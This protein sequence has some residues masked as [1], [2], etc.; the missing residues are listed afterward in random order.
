MDPKEMKSALKS[1]REAIRQKEYKEALKHCKSILKHDK[2]HYNALVFVGVAAEG[3]E[4]TEQALM[5]F[6]KAT[7]SDPS[8]LLAWQGLCRFY[9]KA[10]QDGHSS[11]LCDVYVKLMGLSTDSD[12]KQFEISMKLSRLLSSLGRQSDA[13]QTLKDSLKICGEENRTEVHQR[14]MACI[15]SQ[16]DLL[17]SH[18]SLSICILTTKDIQTMKSD[19]QM[20]ID[21]SE[22]DEICQKLIAERPQLIR[23]WEIT[24]RIC[25]DRSISGSCHGDLDAVAEKLTEISG[26]GTGILNALNGYQKLKKR[27][28]MDAKLC[29]MQGLKALGTNHLSSWIYLSKCHLAMHRK[30]DALLSANKAQK[31]LSQMDIRF[32]GHRERASCEVSLLQAAI[33]LEAGCTADDAE[34]ALAKGQEVLGQCADYAEAS[35]SVI[36]RSLLFLRQLDLARESIRQLKEMNCTQA[37]LLEGHLLLVQG[38]PQAAIEK[39]E[40]FVCLEPSKA[41]GHLLLAKALAEGQQWSAHF[42]HLLA[43]AKLDQYSYEVFLLLGHYYKKLIKDPQKARRCYQKAHDLNP[44]D[45]ESGCSLVDALNE[46][47]E[48]EAAVSVLTA[49]VSGA[50]SGGAKWAWLRLGLYQLKTDHA[51]SAVTSL[52]AALRADPTDRSCLECL[53]EAY[54]ARGSFP[55]ALRTFEKAADL[56]ASSIYSIY[57]I[58][59]LKQHL[60]QYEAAIV[61]YGS[62]LDLDSTHVPAL[63][64]CGETH[65]LL[66]ADALGESM[67]GR[68]VNH[69]QLAIALLTRAATKRPD[70]SCVWKLLGD[71]CGMLHALP[72]E[73]VK[74]QVPNALLS[75]E[76]QGHSVLGQR[77]LLALA[78][79]CYGMALKQ[80][81]Q[82]S[83][84]WHDLGVAYWRHS[85][86]SL[87]QR[88]SLAEKGLHAMRKAV[89][90]QPSN[91]AHWNTLGVIAADVEYYALAQHAFIKSIQVD[92]NNAAAWSHLGA[93]YLLSNR[94]ETAHEAFKT[95]QSLE[96]SFAT[97]WIGQ[98][99]VA[100]AVGHADAMDL[101]RHTTDLS[102]HRESALGYAHWVCHTLMHPVTSDLYDYAIIQ[103]RAVLTASDSMAKFTDCVT[104]DAVSFNF[105]GLLL[106]RQG[107]F[108]SA[109]RAF[110]RSCEIFRQQGSKDELRK[111]R[112]NHARALSALGE[113]NAALEIYEQMNVD[114]FALVASRALCLFE[115]ERLHDSYAMYEAALGIA[116][117]DASKSHTLTAMGMAAFRS[118]DHERAKTALFQAFQHSPPSEQGLLAL[119]GLG[120]ILK[121]ATLA[122]AVLQEIAHPLS[123]DLS[124]LSLRSALE[125]M[126]CSPASAVISHLSRAVHLQPNRGAAWLKLSKSLMQQ[127]R[128]GLAWHCAKSAEILDSSQE[129]VLVS[130]M[131]GL[132][133]G[134]HRLKNVHRRAQKAVHLYPDSLAAWCSLLACAQAERV[135]SPTEEEAE[136]SVHVTLAAQLMAKVE[137]QMRGHAPLH[138]WCVA[139][140]VVALMTVGRK[141][142]A[143][144]FLQQATWLYEDDQ[145]LQCL[146]ALVSQN[147]NV[148]KEAAT[149][150]SDENSLAWQFLI[151][152]YLDLQMPTEAEVVYGAW[153][154]NC[155]GYLQQIARAQF[156]FMAYKQLLKKDE[157]KWREVLKSN[158][159]EVM[160]QGQHA[161]VSAKLVVQFLQG[162]LALRDTELKKATK[163]FAYV[164]K[165]ADGESWVC[166]EADRLMTEM[167][168][169]EEEKAAPEQ[170]WFGAP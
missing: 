107:L 167:E 7:Q 155:D 5:A 119:L 99:L 96:P 166:K 38:D 104:T 50:A 143:Q 90:L 132:H 72:A 117:D 156:C 92:P 84:L 70:L 133:S 158:A 129:S 43:A 136:D 67:Q 168:G 134:Q 109:V 14:I 147:L 30:N 169:K 165:H 152:V 118:G 47:D 48:Q 170:D 35:L 18:S 130:C 111:A 125:V 15:E 151:K 29:F 46:L 32:F 66:A 144:H 39:I 154:K 56:D 150:G 81:P 122:A 51:S 79:R 40:A 121:D 108:S 19:F 126:Q 71:A 4:Q 23:P 28:F 160:S 161:A 145:Q 27:E 100:E 94:V 54:I 85:H 93:L 65:V 149:Q 153:I 78:V 10:A 88:A 12:S 123:D 64:G 83:A 26:D 114:S 115:A 55:S 97:S 139:Q 3:L 159:K 135:L 6:T 86:L 103:M 9:E 141:E 17:T 41:T 113:Y 146:L 128:G 157:A 87:D 164:M 95:A 25:I 60:G 137:Q 148:L 34:K 2:T 98:A 13:L 8:Q 42:K 63:K 110:K 106:E 163:C 1:A 53:G 57:Q 59:N 69:C 68:A 124:V 91:A 80:Q 11:A 58:A 24:A 105:Y 112:M 82:V 61:D 101:F 37:L 21:S 76:T 138:V 74:L 127:S 52:Q 89:S 102:F 33:L 73:L 49:V 140:Y 116:P 120:L 142:D 20:E 162:A 22:L 131:A 75:S 16:D 77:E 44:T 36:T 62:I 31:T 45:E